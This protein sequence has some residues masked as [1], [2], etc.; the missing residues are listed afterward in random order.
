MN[1]LASHCSALLCQVDNKL[2]MACDAFA[3]FTKEC[4]GVEQMKRVLEYKC[5]HRFAGY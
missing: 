5:A 1:C 2:N 3:G 4:R